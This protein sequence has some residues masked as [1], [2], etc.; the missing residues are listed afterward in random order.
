MIVTNEQQ[1]ETQQAVQ[2]QQRGRKAKRHQTER[3]QARAAPSMVGRPQ[4]NG[5]NLGN[6]RRCRVYRDHHACR[7]YR[8]Y[9]VVFAAAAW[10]RRGLMTAVSSIGIRKPKVLPLFSFE[11]NMIPPP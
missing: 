9:L 7:Y 2:R 5:A 4:E 10:L 3:R 11:L 8:S 6:F 1:E